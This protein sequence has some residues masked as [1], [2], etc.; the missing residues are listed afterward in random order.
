MNKLSK[1]KAE[2]NMRS[3]L[4]KKVIFN[5]TETNK[6]PNKTNTL[7][8]QGSLLSK[9]YLKKAFFMGPV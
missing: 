5:V 1:I 9:F 3:Y 4:N 7:F 6:Q 2:V 8:Y